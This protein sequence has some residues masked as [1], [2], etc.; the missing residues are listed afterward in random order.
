[1]AAADRKAGEW[2][3]VIIT[4]SGGYVRN[5]LTFYFQG[6]ADGTDANPVDVMV[7]MADVQILGPDT[8]PVVVQYDNS[9]YNPNQ[10]INSRSIVDGKN[11]YTYTTRGTSYPTN[12][13]WAR[14][15]N[16]SFP[17]GQTHIAIEFRYTEAFKAD[18]V[19]PITDIGLGVYN[20]TSGVGSPKIYDASGTLVA[21]GNAKSGLAVDQWYTLIVEPGNYTSFALWTCHGYTADAAVITMEIRDRSTYVSN[22]IAPS[23]VETF[24]RP[25]L[26]WT[27]ADGWHY[28]IADNGNTTTAWNRRTQITLPEDGM[29]QLTYEAKINSVSGNATQRIRVSSGKNEYYDLETGELLSSSESTFY[30]EIGKW[31]KIVHTSNNQ[32]NMGTSGYTFCYPGDSGA[33]GNISV[34]FRNFEAKAGAEVTVTFN[35]NGAEG[36]APTSI[37]VPSGSAYGEL[38]TVEREGYTFGGWYTDAACSG[39]AVTATATVSASHTLYAK[40]EIIPDTNAIKI[41]SVVTDGTISCDIVD[42]EYVY[43]Y[44]TAGKTTHGGNPKRKVN[45]AYPEDCNY[46]AV[47]FRFTESKTAAGAD[48]AP[49]LRVY[50]PGNSGNGGS[51]IETIWIYDAAG[52]LVAKNNTETGLTVGDWYTLVVKVKSGTNINMCALSHYATD[53]PLVTMQIRERSYYSHVQEAA[54]FSTPWDV[55]PEPAICYKDGEWFYGIHGSANTSMTQEHKQFAVTLTDGAAIEVSFEVM[56]TNATGSAIAHFWNS[57]GKVTI[58]DAEGN[59][60]SGGALQD[61][62][63]YTWVY[64]NGGAAL[65]T[66]TVTLGYMGSS[67]GGIDAF[68]R[69]VKVV[70]PVVTFATPGTFADPTTTVGPNGIEYS[71]IGTDKVS[72]AERKLTATLINGNATSLSFEIKLSNLDSANAKIDSFGSGLTVKFYDISSNDEVT[73]LTADTWYKM[74]VTKTDGSALGT[75]SLTLGNLGGT[76]RGTGKLDVAIRNAVVT[77]P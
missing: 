52:R 72:S 69:N 75:D 25:S 59:P 21:S 34:S 29:I 49:Y 33:E 20:G 42:G 74:V 57:S 67:T 18:G 58:Y 12:D 48:L 35:L 64:A 65:G 28:Y 50:D 37:T 22:G 27:E 11:V 19:T 45:I 30:L 31:Y 10:V 55:F 23:T 24:A 54:V 14:R 39:T 4:K 1:M 62:V 51:V 70:T 32:Q 15:L 73:S 40:W 16:I 60:V 2:Y 77:V 71:I 43:T 5:T 17:A 9:G 8:N 13:P 6:F 46:V 41:G 76:G 47:E 38:P 44:T 7:Q 53:V 3:D 26:I 63:W 68:I 56:M 66:E 36:T 61:G